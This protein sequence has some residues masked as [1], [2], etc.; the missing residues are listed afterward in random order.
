MSIRAGSI[1]NVGGRNVVDR[2]QTVGLDDPRIPIEAIREVGNDLV[3]DKIPTEADFT[4]RMESWDV[5]TDMMAFLHGEVGTQ[6]AADP[7]GAGDP[8]GTVYR[9]E[10]C[11][12]VHIISPWK[13][14]TGPQGGNI[15]AGLIIPNYYVTRLRYR[16][17]VTDWAVQE[18]ELPGGTFFYATAAPVEEVA[19]APDPA[20]VGA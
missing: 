16:F 4:F 12:H 7:P 5:S 6:V 17:G 10:D 19:T 18:A 20:G 14:D 11:E 13:R 2:L 3:V 9:W 15:A 1:I 8:A